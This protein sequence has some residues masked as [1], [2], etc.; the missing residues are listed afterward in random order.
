MRTIIGIG[1]LLLSVL[2]VQQ[3]YAQEDYQAQI[4]ELRQQKEQI[5][6][7]E[8]EALKQEVESINERMDKGMITAEEAKVLKENAARKRAL[9][10]EDR[11]AIIDN[12]IALLERNEGHVLE[13]DKQYDVFEDGVGVTIN[14]GDEPWDPFKSQTKPPK[15]DR[16]TYS[17]LV[18]AFGLNNAIIEGQSL[19]DSPYKTWGSRFFEIGWGWR[20]RVFNN[21]NW[22][23]FHYGLSFHFNG[24]KSKNDQFFVVNED[25][26]VE[27]QP[28]GRSLDKSK[29]R[30]DNLVI[31]VHFEIGPSRKSETENMIRY[32]LR[33]QFRLG[34]GGYGGLNIGHRQKIKYEEN[35]NNVKE[36][37]KG[38]LDTN[39]FVY[40]LS[41]YIGVDCFLLYVKYDLN[42]IFNNSVQEQRNISFGLRFDLDM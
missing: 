2:I 3:V 15:Y 18:V 26:Q 41:G 5:E 14:V 32:S 42:P 6:T 13:T 9:N 12:Q 36:K 24:L 10:I 22:L 1:V 29:L 33:D 28:F 34:F 25:G 31:P 8:R 21:S 40:G 16:R 11:K 7:Q 20:T 37:L 23:R 39:D 30:L 17:D 4:E 38:G 19:N 27:Q 35:G